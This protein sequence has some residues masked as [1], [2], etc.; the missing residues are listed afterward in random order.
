LTTYEAHTIRKIPPLDPKKE[1]SS[2]ARSEITRESLSP[3]EVAKQ[4]KRLNESRRTPVSVVDKKQALQPFQQKQVNNLLDDLNNGEGDRYFAYSLVQLD[5]KIRPLKH[6]QRETTVI[7]VYVKRAP[8]KE[9]SPVAIYH[10]LEKMKAERMANLT[11]PPPPPPQPQ[12]MQQPQQ[13]PQQG[14][15]GKQGGPE[16]I[17]IEPGDKGKDKDQRRNSKPRRQSRR[18]YQHSDS[19]SSRSSIFDSEDDYSDG[20]SSADT[21]KSSESMDR[22]YGNRNGRRRS[23]TRVREHRR[24]F[25]ID[26]VGHSPDPRIRDSFGG[27]PIPTHVPEVPRGVPTVPPF[28]PVAAAY[29]A[30]KIDADSE[31]FGLDRTPRVRPIAAERAI[32]SYGRLEPRFAPEGRYEPRFDTR[33]H[34]DVDDFRYRDEEFR[35]REV[36]D[37]IDRRERDSRVDYHRRTS[38]PRVIY[39]N[40]FATRRSYAPSYES[41]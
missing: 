40:P 22:R 25:L 12:P 17:K 35:R 36:E 32:V 19:H 27:G 21:S 23:Q 41:Y 20:Y 11:R 29:H 18:R 10:A 28:D 14:G 3:E 13:Q 39:N 26:D 9:A 7:T 8:I 24:Q 30:G 37:Y 15:Q 5:S 33:Y 16:I 6:G 38:E 34:D 1:K 31:R 4:V 2:W